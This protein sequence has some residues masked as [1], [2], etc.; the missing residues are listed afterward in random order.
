[1]TKS[2]HDEPTLSDRIWAGD[3]TAVEEARTR[4][5]AD[6]EGQFIP[7]VSTLYSYRGRLG[8]TAELLLLKEEILAWSEPE[9]LY[10]HSISRYQAADRADVLSTVLEWM[11]GAPHIR[12]RYLDAASALISAA[13]RW[14]K[15]DAA[16]NHTLLLLIL[17]HASIHMRRG[18]TL[19]AQDCL[20]RAAIDAG[21][22][23]TPNQ[24]ARVYRKL[25]AL[26]LRLA[27]MTGRVR[28]MPISVIYLVRALCVWSIPWDVRR[29]TLMFWR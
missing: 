25:G 5:Q 11:P 4:Y 26:Y 7:W 17:T 1:M 27:Q 10:N 21:S 15:Y 22:I 14:L 23:A 16:G 6:P 20:L 12:D 13:L 19:A 8:Y 18:D 9:R 3:E 28:W 24:R 29:K 2:M